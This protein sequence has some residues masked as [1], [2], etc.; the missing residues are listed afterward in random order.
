VQAL[1]AF[2]RPL[3]ILLASLWIRPSPTTVLGAYTIS[4]A[5]VVLVLLVALLSLRERLS[6]SEPEMPA[7]TEEAVSEASLMRQMVTYALPFVVFGV[8][9]SLGAMASGFC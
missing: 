3:I 7:S 6:S 5:L 2:G 4:S 1:D 8:V 9:G